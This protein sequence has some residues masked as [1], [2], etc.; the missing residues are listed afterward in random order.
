MLDEARRGPPSPGTST[1]SR[2]PRRSRCDASRAGE[3]A[4]RRTGAAED[5]D[6]HR[7]SLAHASPIPRGRRHRRDYDHCHGSARRQEHRDHR[8]PHRRVAGVRGGRAG[9]GGG[10]RDRAH[11]RRSGAEPHRSARRASCR[12]RSRCS[13]STSPSP[14]T[15]TTV[16]DALAD[17]VGPRRRRAAR[18][19]FRA[20]GVP[21]RRLHGAARGTTCRSRCTS[22]AYSL[23]ALADAFV[24]LM[25]DGGSFVGLDFDNTRRLAGL[26]LDGRRQVGAGE[27]Q[28]LPRQGARAAGHPLQPRRRRSGEDDGGQEHPRASRS[29]RTSGTTA[30]RSAGTSP[31]RRRSPRRAC[32]A[33]QRLVPRR[34]PARS[35]TSTAATTPPPCD[36]AVRRGNV[37]A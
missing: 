6:A 7:R 19:R 30:P 17:E 28:P 33:A 26:Q 34:P 32:A 5:A 25:T 12:R 14:S 3:R 16:R 18:D 22:R 13:S 35:S 31:T 27:R 4:A 20:R 15:S 9:A 23:K 10:R 8:R 29:S 2:S 11:R 36:R 37:D 1:A 21:R 24:P